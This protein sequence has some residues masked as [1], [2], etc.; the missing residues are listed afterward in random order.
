[1]KNEDISTLILK[2][3]KNMK[4]A[5][6]KELNKFISSKQLKDILCSK[7]GNDKR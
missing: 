2:Y 6:F 5:E 1:M 4:G 3:K 7:I